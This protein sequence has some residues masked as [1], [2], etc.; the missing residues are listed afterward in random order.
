MVTVGE[1]R[2]RRLLREAA[3][4]RRAGAQGADR[5]R[6]ARRGKCRS[7]S[8][9]TEPGIVVHKKSGRK[10]G[11]GDLAKRA[12]VPDPMPEVSKADLKPLA[13][14]ASSA[15]T[16]R[17]STCRSR[18]TARRSTA[19]IRSCRT[20]S[21][22]RCCTRRC[23]ARS[24]KRSTMPPPR[25][26]RASSRSRRCRTASPSIGD[27][28]EATQEGQGGAQG[29]LDRTTSPARKHSNE[30]ARRR[31]HQDRRRLGTSVRR[32]AQARRRRRR[33]R[34]GGQGALRR[35]HRRPCRALSAWSR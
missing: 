25:R 3:P 4:R 1:H 15:R 32:H 34:Q 5:Q 35:F 33:D 27:T 18:S 29:H 26:S 9:S 8:S 2:R 21:T 31:L 14:S 12:K 24:R 22:P 7:T 10:I 6:R 23:R 11:Y 16:W 19:S 17:A 30:V 20:C 13:N 28:V